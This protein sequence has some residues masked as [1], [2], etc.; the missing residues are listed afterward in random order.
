M[1]TNSG[2]IDDKIAF[3]TSK[4]PSGNAIS[5]TN[6]CQC[7]G[8]FH[9]TF[10]NSEFHFAKAKIAFAG[11]KT[12]IPN[13]CFL[14]TQKYTTTFVNLYCAPANVKIA[15]TNFICFHRMNKQFDMLFF[16]F[17][18]ANFAPRDCNLAI[19]GNIKEWKCVI[20]KCIS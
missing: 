7:D 20:Q 13:A 1:I 18:D 19:V 15:P 17:E 6:T 14:K 10:Y 2:A 9:K 3:T 12:Q 11:V 4:M 8:Q 5:N 16:E